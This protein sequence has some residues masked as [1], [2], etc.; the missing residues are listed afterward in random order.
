[1]NWV[2]RFENGS[3]KKKFKTQKVKKKILFFGLG[4]T[5]QQFV[6]S[7]REL[8]EKIESQAKADRSPSKPAKTVDEESK[9]D[10]EPKLEVPGFQDEVYA[11]LHVHKR[12]TREKIAKL[13]IQ[14]NGTVC[15]ILALMEKVTIVKIWC[16]L[17]RI[18]PMVLM[19]QKSVLFLFLSSMK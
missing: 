15:E 17:V 12:E 11:I 10:L 1:M 19:F 4:G 6:E 18:M 14:L 8:L 2:T 3:L 16:L 7:D 5:K 9:L 13:L